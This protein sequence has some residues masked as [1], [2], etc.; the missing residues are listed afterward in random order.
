LWTMARRG[1]VGEF[2]AGL[3]Y[4]VPA[5]STYSAVALLRAPLR[6][7][8]AHEGGDGGTRPGGYQPIRRA[9]SGPWFLPVGAERVCAGPGLDDFD[10]DPA[11]W[12][13]GGGGEGGVF[14][15]GC[16]VEADRDAARRLARLPVGSAQS[17]QAGQ[18]DGGVE[19]VDA[20]Q[21]ASVRNTPGG[22]MARA[23]AIELAAIV[24]PRPGCLAPG[25]GVVEFAAVFRRT[26]RRSRW[27]GHGRTGRRRAAG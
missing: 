25:G 16:D 18:V 13:P 2:L 5:S 10:A 20:L 23:P 4:V 7:F 6:H 26:I 24:W 21:S 3:G 19:V 15:V 14:A 22:S 1:R 8:G 27:M 9:G 12:H 11:V 17:R